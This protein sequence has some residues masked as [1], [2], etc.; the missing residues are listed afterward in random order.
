MSKIST[1]QEP[2]ALWGLDETAAYLQVS[3][4]WLQNSGRTHGVPRVRI[5]GLIR[6]V[7]DQV[8]RWALQ[9]QD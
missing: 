6:Y 7:P 9:Q 8:R 5:G 4:R 3:T 2:E 1:T